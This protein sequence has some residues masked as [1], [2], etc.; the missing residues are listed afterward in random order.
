MAKAFPTGRT[1]LGDDLRSGKPANSDLIQ[2]IAEL[3]R[4]RPFLSSKILCRHLRFSKEICFRILHEKRG[5]TRFHLR[6][7]PHQLTPNRIWKP[8]ELPCYL[9]FLLS[10]SIAKQRPLWISW[11][12]TSRGSFWSILIMGSWPRREMKYGNAHDQNWHWK[13]HEFD[14]LVHFCNL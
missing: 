9:S 5:L 14:H 10:S 3:I 2:M 4:K 11:P 6:W 12:G 13:V 7:V 8:Q 1:E